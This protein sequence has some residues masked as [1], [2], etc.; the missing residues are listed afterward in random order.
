MIRIILADDHA[1]VRSGLKQIF[2]Q[3]DDFQVVG[4]A[5]NGFELLALLR[6]IPIDILLLD[7][8]MPG[9]SG[10][11]LIVR[12]KSHYPELPILVLS[13][14]NEPYV[15]VRAIKNGASGYITKDCD[16]NILLPA[17]RQV[18]AGQTFIAPGMAEKMLFDETS[19]S[20]RA[21]HQLLSE[22]ELQVFQLLI[23]GLGVNEIATQL[24]IS[25]KTVSTHKVRMME[26]LKTSSMADLMRYAI[27]HK[28]AGPVFAP[29]APSPL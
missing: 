12:V 8:D 13:M 21:R 23:S 26:K 25:N 3:V 6:Q 4:E 11:E 28:L 1:I 19:N 27:Q 7:F 15:A 29:T 20:E 22:R 24:A 9:I 5:A 14:H 10:P 16:L 18:A 2:A 17:I